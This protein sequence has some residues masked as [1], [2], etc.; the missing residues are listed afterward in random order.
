MWARF[1][2]ATLCLLSFSVELA[3]DSSTSFVRAPGAAA[4]QITAETASPAPA[5]GPTAP[6]D[7]TDDFSKLGTTAHAGHVAAPVMGV[8]ALPPVSRLIP[9]PSSFYQEP[10]LPDLQR[11]PSV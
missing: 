6:N 1:A 4:P 7:D 10:G 9:G 3:L 5:D 2:I 8:H 11:P